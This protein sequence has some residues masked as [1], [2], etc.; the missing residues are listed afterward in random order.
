LAHLTLVS[1][2][3]PNLFWFYRA[4]GLYWERSLSISVDLTQA[5]GDPLEDPR[6]LNNQLDVAFLCGLPFARYCQTSPEQF[7]ALVAPVMTA[8][9]YQ[10]HPVYFSDVIVSATSDLKTFNQLV[11]KTFCYNDPGSNSGYTLMH[12]YLM[13][14]NYSVDFFGKVMQSGSH[15]RSMRWVAEGKVDCAAIDSTVLQQELRMV[16]ELAQQIRVIESIGPCPIPPIVSTRRLGTT[17]LNQLQLALLQ[18][19]QEL[20]SQMQQAGI[21]RFVAVQSEGYAELAQIYD[22]TSDY[23]TAFQALSRLP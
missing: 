15:Q 17:L 13:H 8:D 23:R 2:L 10:D 7:Q 16:P 1:Y 22:R 21:R 4:I 5:Q 19:D 9:R 18:P 6:L 12:Y 3:A 20:Q 11:G 14:N